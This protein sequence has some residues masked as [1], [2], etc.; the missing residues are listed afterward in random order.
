MHWLDKAK[1]KI[2]EKSIDVER[3]KSFEELDTVGGNA[4]LISL[5]DLFINI[6]PATI[7][8]LK[9]SGADITAINNFAH[10]LKSSSSNIG[11]VR[12]AG[13]CQTLESLAD[14]N[15]LNPPN[16][17]APH[18]QAIEGEFHVVQQQLTMIKALA[19]NSSNH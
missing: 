15:H 14:A 18:I 2:E 19:Q 5:I 7:Q 6:A 16:S 8:D 13:L 17:F 1:S 10:S 4:L 11:A 3:L 12:L 9:N